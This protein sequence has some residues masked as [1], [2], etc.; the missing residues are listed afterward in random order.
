MLR[1]IGFAINTLAIAA[2]LAVSAPAQAAEYRYASED[3]DY[4]I[5]FP[6]PPRV[7]TKWADDPLISFL[8]PP[9]AE[10]G[11][12]GEV[13]YYHNVDLATAD[14]IKVKAMCLRADKEYLESLTKDSMHQTLVDAFRDELVQDIE[15]NYSEGSASLRWATLSGYTV[16]KD[17]KITYHY[18]HFLSGLNT[19]LFIRTEYT[20]D[21]P[22]ISK[23]F[24][25]IDQSIVLN[26]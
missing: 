4:S 12:W 10:L 18:G 5:K 21:N 8:P 1:K 14:F 24:A 25:L 3:C 19:I 2:I 20:P 16:G 13:A 11:H 7:A 15:L 26:Q 22:D 23:E 17:E 9:P 6:E